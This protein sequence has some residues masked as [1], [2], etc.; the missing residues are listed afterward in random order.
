[1]S[2]PL[3]KSDRSR[4]LDLHA[5][6]HQA[7]HREDWKA[8]AD[9]DAA[10][11]QCLESLPGDDQLDAATLAAKR[12]LKQLHGEGLQACANE[13]ERLRLLLLKHLEYAEGSAAYQ[14]IDMFQAGEPR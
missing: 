5:R 6:L 14:R 10:I 1:M 8:V 7:L 9:V 12:Q 13:C 3:A 2:T 11:R 4:L